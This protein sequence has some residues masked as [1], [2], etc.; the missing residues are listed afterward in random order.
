M[1]TC[2][3]RRNGARRWA[4]ERLNSLCAPALRPSSLL[5]L[6]ADSR[7][8]PFTWKAQST[9]VGSDWEVGLIE[10]SF[11]QPMFIRTRHD[12]KAGAGAAAG[13]APRASGSSAAN[14]TTASLLD[15]DY[16]MSLAPG[17]RSLLAGLSRL[18]CA[19][20]FILESFPLDAALAARYDEQQ[21]ELDPAAHRERTGDATMEHLEDF[22]QSLMPSA[23]M[24]SA[25]GVP[26][27][28]PNQLFPL[29]SAAASEFAWLRAL[30]EEHSFRAGQAGYDS[31][32]KLSYA[33][34]L[35]ST[36]HPQV[37]AEVTLPARVDTWIEPAA[38]DHCD[39]YVMAEGDRVVDGAWGA[40]PRLVN[41]AGEAFAGFVNMTRS[42]GSG[43]GSDGDG[44]T[45]A[46]AHDRHVS[47]V[48]ER[49]SLASFLAE[50][51]T[52]STQIPFLSVLLAPAVDWFLGMFIIQLTDW[53]NNKLEFNLLAKL[54]DDAGGEN[55][56][57]GGGGAVGDLLGFAFVEGYEPKV[58]FTDTAA[59]T[60][61]GTTAAGAVPAKRADLFSPAGL[62]ELNAKLQAIQTAAGEQVDHATHAKAK[63]VPGA[64]AAATKAAGT[65]AA[66]LVERKQT[67]RNGTRSTKGRGKGKR[68]N[69]S[70]N[71]RRGISKL[72]IA[73]GAQK[74]Q[75]KSARSTIR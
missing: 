24:R 1:H 31:Y 40:P 60:A 62:A 72:A 26:L 28:Q 49:N 8:S 42:G 25:A 67:L 51:M 34:L 52:L 65:K 12:D 59:S 9:W 75:A 39:L 71:N 27:Q 66:S 35:R 45:A 29:A 11:D 19:N 37:G 22:L 54:L 68:R 33:F 50:D 56:A 14:E 61:T 7:P 10:L 20:G 30:A 3:E 6:C 5:S 41:A 43:S 21:R 17:H 38:L 18:I 69:S 13:A 2:N 36:H 23:S 48:A 63:A 47:I 44:E 16:F 73:S 58:R 74:S 46:E 70:S 15:V 55:G 53:V 32:N 4:L 57:G 64:V